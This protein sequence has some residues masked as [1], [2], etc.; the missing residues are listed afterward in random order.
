MPAPT[1][2]VVGEANPDLV[3][4]G[5]VVPRFGQAEQLLDSASL[6][7]GGSGAIV[8]CGLARLG[9]PT[10]LV[11]TVG[12]DV[13]G[14]FVRD[15]LRTAG[16]DLRWL[17]THRTAATG[18]SVILSGE[19]RAILTLPGTI[20]ETDASA[21]PTDADLTGVRHV[22]SASMFLLTTLAPVLAPW[23]AGLRGRGIT[24]SVDTN[25][26]PLESWALARDTLAHADVFLP[27]TAELLAV[28]GLDDVEQAGQ[29]VARTGTTVALKN[30]SDGGVVWTPDGGRATADVVPVDVVDT[31]GAG[32][33]FDAGYL[34]AYVD[35]HPPDECLR[36]AV[37]AGS[38]STRA[39]GGTAS[40]ATADELTTVLGR[41]S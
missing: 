36:R 38:L 17:G 25:W 5:D 24:T 34:A 11:A 7:L 40:Q 35:G 10:A 3:L 13:Y 1:I 16:V 27:N 18:L 30:G 14:D 29:V 9:V 20:A 22:H 23:L 33:S 8:A 19:D 4:T 6:V 32:D 2:V 31:T 26:D 28:T 21:L 37:A 15:A 39:A 41:R 12:D